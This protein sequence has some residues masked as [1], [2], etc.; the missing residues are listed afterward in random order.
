MGK[1]KKPV[2]YDFDSFP[3]A[4]VEWID[5][6]STH[7]WRSLNEAG[8]ARIKSVGILVNNKKD[9]VTLSAAMSEDIKFSDMLT[10]PRA[11]IKKF[12]KLRIERR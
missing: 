1:K 10:I 6:N 11:G 9:Y 8:T 12:Q 4:F 3:I 5:A 7:G 2:L